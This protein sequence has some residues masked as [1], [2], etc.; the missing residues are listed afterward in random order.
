MEC[1]AQ[2]NDLGQGRLFYYLEKKKRKKEEKNPFYRLKS[3][4][5]KS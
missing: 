1:E 4:I 3:S 2:G 5:G